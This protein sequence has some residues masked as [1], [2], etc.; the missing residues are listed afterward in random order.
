[1]ISVHESGFRGVTG[2]PRFLLRV[3]VEVLYDYPCYHYRYCSIP[4]PPKQ[5]LIFSKVVCRDIVHA[6]FRRFLDFYL[7]DDAIEFA[8]SSFVILAEEP[9]YPKGHIPSL[10]AR[11][12]SC[13]KVHP[14]PF[15]RVKPKSSSPCKLAI[16]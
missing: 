13:R 1:M 11:Y 3:L 5:S 16:L 6:L 9:G 4:T 8:V 7:P 15:C 14:E 2:K 12:P 10:V